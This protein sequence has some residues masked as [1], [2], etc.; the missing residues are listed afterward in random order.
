MRITQP[1]NE[2]KAVPLEL[3]QADKKRGR[4]FALGG[5][6]SPSEVHHSES[7]VPLQAQP[8][9]AGEDKLDEEVALGDH[10]EEG[11]RQEDA[12]LTLAE[13]ARHRV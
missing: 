1:S 4:P 7:D 10:V 12:Q 3:T 9:Q 2:K 5:C 11:R 8:A 13:L 6:D